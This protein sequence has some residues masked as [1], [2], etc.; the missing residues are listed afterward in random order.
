MDARP[1]AETHAIVCCLFRLQSLATT[2]F[3]GV[4]FFT[5]EELKKDYVDHKMSLGPPTTLRFLV[6]GWNFISVNSPIPE[7]KTQ[8]RSTHSLSFVLLLS[9][10]PRSRFQSTVIIH[11]EAKISCLRKTESKQTVQ[12]CAFWH[13][14]GHVNMVN[15]FQQCDAYTAKDVGGILFALMR[16]LSIVSKVQGSGRGFMP[17]MYGFGS[18]KKVL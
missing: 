8:Q 11:E 14:A 7:A 1:A 4:E 15:V 10:K 6:N 12:G 13:L 2:D 17:L 16:S 3:H 18:Q 5:S 9:M